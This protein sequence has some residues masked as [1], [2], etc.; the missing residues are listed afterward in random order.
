MTTTE[1]QWTDVLILGGGIAGYRAAVAAMAQGVKT[2]LISRGRGASPYVIGFN[3]PIGSIDDRDTPEIYMQDMIRGG[4]ELNDKRLVS[5]LAEHSIQSF[6]DLRALKVPFS[7]TNEHVSQRHLSGNK[8]ARSVFV[9][10]GTGKSI[11]N[12]LI[13][14]SQQNGVEILTGYKVIELIRCEQRVIGAIVWKYHARNLVFIYA[15]AVV[16]AMGGMGRAFSDTTYPADVNGESFGLAYHAGATLIDMEFIQYEPVVTVWPETCRGMEMP[17][18]ML[19]DGAYLKNATGDRFLLT[20]ANP[21]GEKGVEKA[22]MALLIQNEINEGR[23]LSQGGVA[24][25]TTVLDP[26]IL[27]SYVSH[28]K[29]LRAAGVDPRVTPPIVAPAAHSIMGGVAID[30]KCW[31]GVPGLYVAGEATGGVHGASRIAGNGCADALAFGFIAGV[32]AASDIGPPLPSDIC[33]MEDELLSNIQ[34]VSLLDPKD[35]V[36]ALKDDIRHALSTSAGIYRNESGLRQGSEKVRAVQM[37]IVRNKSADLQESISVTE[38]SNMALASQCVIQAALLREESRG[39]H[40]RL[41]YRSQDDEKWLV[42]IGF[43]KAMNATLSHE[44]L[45]IQ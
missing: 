18:A 29:R 34:H 41:D 40:Q 4:Y 27:E 13:K 28:C 44:L 14:Q 22:R 7:N 45:P 36:Q 21:K 20:P 10:E 3:A 1:R 30:E 33:S 31:S 32:S 19:G 6:K 2:T 35:N 39:A 25:D 23:G 9:P 5:A 37:K 11:L 15:R 24:F 17:T 42:H 8:Y 43:K 26:A 16:L 12:A 38:L